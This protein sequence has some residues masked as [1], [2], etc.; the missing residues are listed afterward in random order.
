MIRRLFLCSLLLISVAEAEAVEPEKAV[1]QIINY[2]QYPDWVEP[3][4]FSPVRPGLGSGFIIEGRRIMTNAHVVSWSKQLIV[5]R[6]QDPKIYRAEIEFIGHDCDLAVLRVSDTAFFEEIE[7]LQIGELP[8][9]RS[10]VTT[11]GYPTGGRQ[12][13]YTRGVISR[14]EMQRYAHIANRS[15]LAVQTDAAINPGNSGGPVL[16]DGLVV[17]VSFQ[18]KPDLENAGFFIPPDVIRHFLKDIEDGRYDGF[19]QA[20]I[21]IQKLNSPAFRRALGLP[22]NGIGARVD[23]IFQP[24]PITHQQIRKNDV[25]LEVEG[26]TVGSDGMIQYKGNRVHV[27]VLFNQVQHGDSIFIKL[28]REGRVIDVNLPLYVNRHDRIMGNQYVEPPYLMVGGLVF[29]EL[30]SNYLRSLGKN[31]HNNVDPKT[32]YELIFRHRQTEELARGKPVVL[33]KILRHPNNID[34][35]ATVRTVLTEV[36]GRA[37]H[38]MH[39]LKAALKVG[40]DGFHHFRFLSGFEEALK[41]SDA[42]IANLELLKQYNIPSAERLELP[43]E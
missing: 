1:V 37:V 42:Q 21:S 26:Y 10:T 31:W 27:R 13:S 5:K 40:S 25:I 15:L 28:W 30:S 3:W 33:S 16:Q 6:Y 11:Y 29:T 36:N 14:I 35:G 8:K 9:P 12:I 43:H 2:A 23:N 41:I 39:D 4:R 19:P 20:G 32:L 18:G 24:Y 22:D 38:S 34:F 17:G 7:P